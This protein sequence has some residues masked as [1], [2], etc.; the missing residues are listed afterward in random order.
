MRNLMIDAYRS[1]GWRIIILFALLMLTGVFEG[2]GLT[3]LLPLLSKFGIGQTSE[4][5]P[6]Q[7]FIEKA[8]EIL[9][10][11]N[12]LWPLLI[13]MVGVL[14]L[15]VFLQTCKFWMESHCKTFYTEYLH[16]KMFHAFMRAGWAFFVA[17]SSSSRVNAIMTE[18][19]RISAAFFMIVQMTSCFVFMVVFLVLSLMSSWQVVAILGI[20]GLLAYV[21]LL[22]L[23]RRSQEIGGK[24][25]ESSEA[26]QHRTMEFINNAKLIKATATEQLAENLFS[27]AT[28]NYRNAFRQEAF[29][30]KLILGMYMFAGYSLLGFGLWVSIENLRLN[31]ATVLVSIYI[32]H[33]LYVQYTNFQQFRQSYLLCS[34]AFPSAMLH[35]KDAEKLV[36]Q[37]DEGVIL[38]NGPVGLSFSELSVRYENLS[39]LNK[40]GLVV[41]PGNVIGITGQSGA[42]KSTLVDV[43]VG[44]VRPFSGKVYLNGVLIDDVSLAD[45]RRSIGYVGQD[46]LLLNGSVFTNIA[47]GHDCTSEEVEAAAQLA[48]A[49]DFICTLQNG[50]KTEIGDR[51]VRLSGGQ[52]QRLGLARALVGNKRLLILDEA[53]SALDSESEKKIMDALRGLRGRVTILTIAHRLSTLCDADTIFMLEHGSLIESGSWAEL[54]RQDGEFAK[55][56][57]LQQSATKDLTQK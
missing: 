45:W 15:Q 11:T 7:E 54:I 36:E 21:A 20:F 55:L 39:A 23:S 40:V 16:K 46:T 53:T 28:S 8:L 57:R 43:V 47:W 9:G 51:G 10:V 44:L 41:E 49:H 37:L 12:E 6:L 33:R 18:A 22:P 42:G 29:H 31:P 25:S 3:M 1:L 34:T 35:I 5:E 56:W 24:V 4:K 38:Q 19:G 52:R 14:Y 26:L 17:Q 50:Y 30:P 13:F 48:N 27:V 32:F 2:L